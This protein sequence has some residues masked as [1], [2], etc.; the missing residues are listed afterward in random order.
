MDKA[1]L[2]ITSGLIIILSFAH[3]IFS[4][5]IYN[6]TPFSEETPAL[7]IILGQIGIVIVTPLLLGYVWLIVRL[8][9]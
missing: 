6:Y 7:K 9:S 8:F 5:E 4:P 1:L 2:V 3:I